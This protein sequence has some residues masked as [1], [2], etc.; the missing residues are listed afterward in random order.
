MAID[1]AYYPDNIPLTV[2]QSLPLPPGRQ[3]YIGRENGEWVR[4]KLNLDA[5]DLDIATSEHDIRVELFMCARSLGFFTTSF[6]IGLF[7]P[8]IVKLGAELFA[9]SYV[10]MEPKDGRMVP[11]PDWARIANMIATRVERELS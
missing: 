2:I 10:L 9:S 4:D 1:S 8:S 11:V 5:K 3:L 7:A 6:L